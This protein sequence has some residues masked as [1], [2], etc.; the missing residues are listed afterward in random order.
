MSIAIIAC[1][2]QMPLCMMLSDVLTSSGV[3][4]S[5]CLIDNDFHGLEGAIKVTLPLW[6][7][8]TPAEGPV[9]HSGSVVITGGVLIAGWLLWRIVKEFILINFSKSPANIN[10]E[11][12]TF[13]NLLHVIARRLK[14][15]LFPARRQADLLRPGQHAFLSCFHKL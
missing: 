9:K 7:T 14:I 6:Q 10:H 15:A 1:T 3:L 13:F 8:V 4:I 2:A 5:F 11:E 12:F